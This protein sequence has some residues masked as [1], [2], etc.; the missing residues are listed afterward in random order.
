IQEKLAAAW[1]LNTSAYFYTRH[2]TDQW[3]TLHQVLNRVALIPPAIGFAMLM[4]GR[5]SP[6]MPNKFFVNVLRRYT[7]PAYLLL[8]G[9]MAAFT[10]VLG[11][12]NEVF[13]ALVAGFL[14]FM[15]AARRARLWR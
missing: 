15:S 3:F 14:A 7:V 6:G 9:L 1:T 13:M 2:E 4:A 12:K 8:F 11:N 5:N 10:F